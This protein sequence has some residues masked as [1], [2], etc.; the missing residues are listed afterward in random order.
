MRGAH[1]KC[2]ASAA[3]CV[4]RYNVL[5]FCSKSITS[6]KT[7][8]QCCAGFL[9]CQ[10]LRTPATSTFALPDFLLRCN[11]HAGLLNSAGPAK[12]CLHCFSCALRYSATNFMPV[13]NGNIPQSSMA[14]TSQCV[15]AIHL[16]KTTLL[17]F[18]GIRHAALIPM[19]PVSSLASYR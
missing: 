17:M 1:L 10:L 15:N 9:R 16:Q 5:I 6:H 7:G 12:R 2:T 3:S 8:K 13:Q 4:H 18:I 14:H 19:P 11:C